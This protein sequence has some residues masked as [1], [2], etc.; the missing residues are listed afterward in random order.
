MPTK[1]RNFKL[2]VFHAVL[3]SVAALFSF[4]CQASTAPRETANVKPASITAPAPAAVSSEAD[5]LPVIVA[6]GD[7]LTAGYGLSEDQSYTALLQQKLDQKGFR[8]RVTN[9]GVSGDT[10]AGGV[11]RIDW[12]LDGPV[13][14]LIL[15]LGGNDRL[16]GLPVADMK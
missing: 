1:N 2:Q 5:D 16:R 12:A 4:A 3:L 13:K 15:E 9:A 11:R 7:S 10:S 14:F 8:Y 6:F